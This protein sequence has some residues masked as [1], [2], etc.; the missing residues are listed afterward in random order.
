MKSKALKRT[1]SFFVTAAIIAAMF[2]LG[3][4]ASAAEGSSV[5]YT[6]TGENSA[7]AGYAEGTITFKTRSKAIY[8]LY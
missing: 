8:Y 7:D 6:F 2:A 3:I 4:P 5:S 1:I